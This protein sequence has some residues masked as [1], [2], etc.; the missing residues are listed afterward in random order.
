[1]SF[2]RR[3]KGMPP[4]FVEGLVQAGA[5]SSCLYS[6]YMN[7]LDQYGSIL[8]GGVDTEKYKGPLTTLN[9]LRSRNTEK[10]D[11]FFLYLEEIKMES[12]NEPSQTILRPTNDSKLETWVDTGCPD[13]HIPASAYQE[14]VKRA[15]G[16]RAGKLAR[17]DWPGV[18]SSHYVR[19]CG[20]VARGFINTTHF[21]ITF[22]G[23]GSQTAKLHLELADLFSP[24]TTKDGSA[25]TDD[26]GRPLCFLRVIEGN[27]SDSMTS[28]SVMR[29]GYWVFDLDNGQVSIAQANLGANSSNVIQVEAGPQGLEKAAKNVRAETQVDEVEGQILPSVSYTLSTA[30]NTIGYATGIE[31]YPT[32]TGAVTQTPSKNHSSPRGRV[33]SYVRRAESAAATVVGSE[34]HGF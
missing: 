17:G 30:P 11:N 26:T 7:T 27:P 10:V 16:E 33:H 13:W 1:M 4:T 25:A 15:G 31:S 29:A 20:E 5:I 19:P 34:V 18:L 22:A 3:K 28:N 2:R 24:I 12:S 21:E 23:N 32:P 8:F 6:I 14:V 9:L